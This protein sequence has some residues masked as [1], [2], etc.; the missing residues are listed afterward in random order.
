MHSKY[1]NLSKVG[2]DIFLIIPHSVGVEASFSLGRDV[3]GR[4][5]SK[6]TGE[7][8]REKVVVRQFARTNCRLL[9][10]DDPVLDPDSTDNDM[11][12]KREAEETMLHRMAKIH[13]ILEMWQGSQTLRATQ[14]ESRTQNKQMTAVGYISDTEEI[15]KTSLSNFHHDRSAAFKLS[16][17][18]PVPP[19][20]S[21]KDPHGRRSQVLNVCR[22]KRIDP[23]PAESDEHR[24]PESISD[25][26]N[27]LNWNGDL[28]NP[29]DSEDDWE[30]DN[31]SNTE[32]DNGIED[33]ETAEVQNVSAALNVPGLIQ[34]MW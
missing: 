22:I 15:V 18:S 26:E 1:A 25:T 29:F 10:G 19:A 17:K 16:E 6:T 11:E 4:R 3:I 28:D 13:N 32:L 24:L 21:A 7:T 30:A 12:M 8:L 2:C 33:L 14:K 5:Q 34:P 9:A 27:W 20:L 23:H 31:E